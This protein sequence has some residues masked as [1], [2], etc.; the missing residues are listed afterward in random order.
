[1]SA[2]PIVIVGH[3]DHGK[4]TLIGRLLHD[5]GALSDAKVAELKRVSERRQ[6]DFEWSYAL[7][8]LQLER[9]QAITVDSTHAWFATQKRR[10]VIVDAPGHHEFLRNMLT[11]AAQA[12]A[13]VLVVDAA[14]GM[15]AQTRRH[16]RVLA[17]LGVT[18]VIAA[19]NKMDSVGYDRARFEAVAA[20]VA[21]FAKIAGLTVVET[22][23]LSARHGDN[24]AQASNRLTWWRGPTL[25]EALDRLS[26]RPAAADRPLR[27]AVQD[28]YRHDGR[29]IVVGRLDG[30]RLRVGDTISVWPGG[31]EARVQFFETWNAA[32]PQIS[33]SAP[34]SVAF[35]LDRDLFIERGHVIAAP[36]APPGVGR[37]VRVR[38]LW[39]GPG[40][41]QAGRKLRLTLGAAQAD[42]TV[43][44]L[45]AVSEDLGLDGAPVNAIVDLT[46]TAAA[47]V[48]FDALGGGS[49]I[50]RGSLTEGYDVVGGCVVLG[51][52][53]TQAAAE[54]RTDDRHSGAVYWLTGLSGAGKTTL[55]RAAERRLSDRG[56][57]VVVID[58][59][60]LRR[61]LS[62][63]LGFDTAA[64]AENVRRG[65]EVAKL[66]A[67]SGFVVLAAFMSPLADHRARARAIV[68]DAFHEIFIDAGVEACAARDVKGLYAAAQNGTL[69]GL[70]GVTGPWQPPEAPDLAIGAG[71]E[72]ISDSTDRLVAYIDHTA[73]RERAPA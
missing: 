64:R 43:G 55:A 9:D 39:L 20:D 66:L 13:A 53:Q 27:L 1:M 37:E 59:D 63:D 18:Q 19:V 58:G 21:A 12:E 6:G 50:G 60:D 7:D 15:A 22:V 41:L 65:A 25:V 4:S 28:V 40:P 2:F 17:L 45:Q 62:S 14:Q 26:P 69:D 32:Q 73:F 56:A 31:R 44:D 35:T 48:V 10:Y 33:A 67:N 23:P 38:A 3:V 49:A 52:N 72:S 34:Q 70:S 47:E 42:V 57:R 24:L 11:G 36:I 8:A 30:G 46:L 61:G 5:L 68:G 51:V 54:R 29:R 71:G 16:A